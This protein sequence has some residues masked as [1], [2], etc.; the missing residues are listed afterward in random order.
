MLADMRPPA[1]LGLAFLLVL[2]SMTKFRRR[3]PSETLSGSLDLQILFELAVYGVIAL[4]VVVAAR[5]L[6]PGLLRPS[7]TEMVL[8][9]FTLFAV[10]S[11]AWSPTMNVTL[12]R[13]GQAFVILCLVAV[14][15]R[16]LGPD[17]LR[18]AVTWSVVAYVLVF[19]FLAVTLPAARTEWDMEAWE[20]T[21][22][23]AWF[24]VH[25]ITAGTLAAAAV[26]LLVME[27]L[28][29][30]RAR[31][32]RVGRVPLVAA[33]P[34]LFAVVLAAWSRG[35]LFGMT[36]ACGALVLRR[37]LRPWR[38]WVPLGFSLALACVLLVVVSSGFLQS[39]VQRSVGSDNV[40]V[41]FLTR[42]N[43]FRY[44][45][46]LGGR[47]LLWQ[48]IV[49]LFL[50]RPWIGWGY[51]ASRGLLPRIQEWA[52]YSHNA[53]AQTLLDVGIV[54]SL[55]LW[56]ALFRALFKD[57]WRARW[58]GEEGSARA[59]VFGALLML[60]VLSI[61]SETFAGPPG[62]ELLLVFTCILVSSRVRVSPA[63]RLSGTA[64]TPRP[65][66]REPDHVAS[67]A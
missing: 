58:T 34:L 6:R 56:L 11:A 65:H 61:V 21:V 22:R 7:A 52:S 53:L 67:T 28:F 19:S 18:R 60:T 44:L 3:D 45:S 23:F 62:Y 38:V 36:A 15:L 55:P 64:P 1:G 41:Q 9:L 63:S 50:E 13:A 35:P 59:F 17:G 30:P 40:V 5:R 66:R 12:V 26:V 54:G 4:I 47:V 14:S 49:D 27:A 31:W 37:T 42:G 51:S 29:V 39:V 10:A 8:L 25:P 33:L 2:L 48:G 16:W 57:L 43:D 20:G 24:A 46:T 32:M